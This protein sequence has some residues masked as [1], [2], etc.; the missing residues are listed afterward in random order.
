MFK[1]LE[2][3]VKDISVDESIAGVHTRLTEEFKFCLGI[4]GPKK[5]QKFVLVSGC[6]CFHCYTQNMVAKCE[7]LR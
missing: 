1:C 4:F 6:G 2:K 3:L 7:P 5:V